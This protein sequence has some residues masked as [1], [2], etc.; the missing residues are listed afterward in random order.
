MFP[1]LEVRQGG[2]DPV[3]P[4]SGILIHSGCG[5]ASSLQGTKYLCLPH[6]D[7]GGDTTIQSHPESRP[8]VLA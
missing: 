8:S 7:P 3:P 5:A 1:V 6:G 4:G 2:N